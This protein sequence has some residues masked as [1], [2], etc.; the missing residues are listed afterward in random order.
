MAFEIK[1]HFLRDEAGGGVF[2]HQPINYSMAAIQQSSGSDHAGRKVRRRRSSTSIDMTPMV[3]LAFL[4][5]TF[6][7]LTS[8]LHKPFML[9][10]AMPAKP[11]PAVQARPELPAHKVLTLVLGEG[12]KIYWYHGIIDPTVA[13]TSFSSEGIRKVLLSKNAE[14]PGMWVL[15]KP[16]PKSRYQN[17]IDIFDEM[18][19][20]TITNYA[21]VKITPE[22]EKL[23]ERA[24]Q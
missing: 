14:I 5:L 16:S 11:D 9:M 2:Y 7:I 3:D 10:V 20:A 8:S 19:I 18:M 6:F 13:L 12:D 17:I 1:I 4:L 24:T 23:I 21:L 15:I 22:D